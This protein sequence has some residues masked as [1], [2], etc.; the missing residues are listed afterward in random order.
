MYVLL[1]QMARR[2]C[3][4]RKCAKIINTML[5]K[6]IHFI[7]PNCCSNKIDSESAIKVDDVQDR[8]TY[9]MRKVPQPVVVVTTALC[10]GNTV[11]KRGVTCSSFTSTS[12]KPPVI[13][14]AMNL[15]S[16]MHTMLLETRRFVV[17]VL[18]ENQV[19]YALHF[20][21]PAVDGQ[22]QFEAIE[23]DLN[24]D[25]IPILRDTC[26][27]LQCQKY[28]VSEIG[29]HSVW[30]GEVLHSY[31]NGMLPQNPL[32]HYCRGFHS[33]GDETFVRAFEN[34]TLSFKDWTHEAHLRMAWYYVRDLGKADAIPVIK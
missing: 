25:G 8:F 19:G 33:I 3:G 15:P 2:N 30:Y 10:E 4:T 5:N 23:H 16:R 24:S 20:S 12:L 7:S 29:D 31:R 9:V 6:N 14:F 1:S 18:A 13:S 11:L 26:A 21:K 34:Q 32:L 27:V 17:H 28:T 22:D